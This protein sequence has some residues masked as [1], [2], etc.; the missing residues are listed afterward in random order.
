MS[1]IHIGGQDREFLSIEI[2]TRERSEPSGEYFDDNWLSCVIDVRAGGFRGSVP[3]SL[4]AE[5]FL[6]L[7]EIA[8]NLLNGTTDNPSFGT[9]EDWLRIDFL[10][11]GR[12]GIELL[13]D[14]RDLGGGNRLRFVLRLDQSY[15]P[16][17]ITDLNRA[18]PEYP[19]IGQPPLP[20]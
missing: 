16:S 18:I 11:D 14:L 2:V 9:L 12:G 8:R 10:V 4:L 3:C 13:G 15:L 19:V 7:R 1:R 17:F 20:S 6:R 5:D